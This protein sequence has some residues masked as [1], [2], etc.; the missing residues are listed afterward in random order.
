M[1]VK[2]CVSIIGII[3]NDVLLWLV[4]AFIMLAVNKLGHAYSNEY[5]RISSYYV[6]PEP[7]N[8]YGLIC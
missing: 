2:E 4:M 7:M 6:N 1:Q 5:V 8:T 3:W